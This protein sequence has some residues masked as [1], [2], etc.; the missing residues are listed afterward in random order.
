MK[1][2]HQMDMDVTG[3]VVR[4]FGAEKAVEIANWNGVRIPLFVGGIFTGTATAS[5]GYWRGYF[6]DVGDCAEC[7][8]LF[9]AMF[10]IVHSSHQTIQYHEFR[11]LPSTLNNQMISCQTRTIKKL[12][13]SL[14][15]RTI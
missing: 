5:A 2:R 13:Q 10:S 15:R 9:L 8:G 14:N 6:D 12:Q 4:E 7:V 1:H 3:S 11:G